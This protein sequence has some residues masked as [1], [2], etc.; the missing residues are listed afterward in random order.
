VAVGRRAGQDEPA[1]AD[2]GQPGAADRAVER[3]RRAVVHVDAG[4]AVVQDDG[5]GPGAPTAGAGDVP[6]AAVG[7]VV[8]ERVDR[9]RLVADGDVVETELRLLLAR[10]AGRGRP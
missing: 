1:L 6:Q 10:G 9:Q 2:L 3:Q 4:E 7:R 5:G 8:E